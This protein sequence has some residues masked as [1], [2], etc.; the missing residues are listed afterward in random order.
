MQ[1]RIM[2][3]RCD[4]DKIEIHQVVRL[5]LLRDE[6]EMPGIGKKSC[7][8]VTIATFHMC[9]LHHKH[10]YHENDNENNIEL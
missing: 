1:I 4:D 7:Y 2:K 9:Y 5:L 10:R 6:K 3:I 8:K